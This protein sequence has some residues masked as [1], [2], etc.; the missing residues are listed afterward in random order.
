MKSIFS[1]ENK[2][3]FY[4]M[5]PKKTLGLSRLFA[6]LL[7]AS[8][9]VLLFG[10]IGSGKSFFARG[11][12]QSMMINQSIRVQEVPSPTFTIVQTYDFLFPS[13]WHIDLYRIS[14][15][16]EI[17]E[18][19][20]EHGLENGICL[21]EWPGKMSSLTPKR[22][23]SITFKSAELNHEMRTIII[24]LN[25]VGWKHVSDGITKRD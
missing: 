4:N 12:I 7:R 1:S 22:N 6:R 16:N 18:L 13:V 19:D 20:L 24:E 9:S 15:I 2:I 17:F 10:E 11:V 3:S 21:I 23:I 14:D 8:D 25:G 5:T